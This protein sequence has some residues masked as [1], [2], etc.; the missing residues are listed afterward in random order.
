MT[1]LRRVDEP[2]EAGRAEG[3]EAKEPVEDD[4]VEAEGAGDE[5][6][7]EEDEL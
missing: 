4:T 5:I 2:V 3:D 1:G 6:P 7:V